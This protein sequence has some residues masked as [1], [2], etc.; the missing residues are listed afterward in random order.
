MKLTE[1]QLV[2]LEA[3]RGPDL[4]EEVEI[5]EP[6]SEEDT[7][8]DRAFHG[9]GK[10]CPAPLWPGTHTCWE[11][12]KTMQCGSRHSKTQACWYLANHLAFCLAELAKA[13]SRG[14]PPP[15]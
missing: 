6:E 4:R 9:W 10:K 15:R 7:G 5:D 12:K 1:E 8:E 13:S 14:T 11:Y 3:R 2:E